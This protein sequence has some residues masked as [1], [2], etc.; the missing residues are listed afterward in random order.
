[1]ALKPIEALEHKERDKWKQA[2]IELRKKRAVLSERESVARSQLKNAIKN[3]DGTEALAEK[4]LGETHADL[5]KIEH[6]LA[7]GGRRFICNDATTEKLAELCQA[8]PYGLM[9]SRDELSGWFEMLTKAGREG[10]RQFFLEAWTGA[11]GHSYDR[12][13]RG[14]PYIPH[15]CLSLFGTI[16]PGKLKYFVTSAGQDGG[17]ADGLLQRFQ[18]L[19][20]PDSRGPRKF[21]DESPNKEAQENYQNVFDNLAALKWQ[22]LFS[23]KNGIALDGPEGSPYYYFHFEDEA[24]SRANEWFIELEAQIDLI[25]V[26]A[27]KA[28]MGKYRGLMPRLALNYFLI[29]VSAERITTQ[30]IPLEAVEFAIEW[31]KHLEAHA[32]K[33]WA[34]NINPALMPAKALAKRILEGTVE[35]RTSL[36]QIQQKNWSKLTKVK[37]VK[38][39]VNQLEKWGWLKQEVLETQGAPSTIILLN[40]ELPL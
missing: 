2:E 33:L 22:S 20:F 21:I 32:R 40:P 29:E 3:A 13:G 6:K 17:E 19:L 12:I 5:I 18:I 9:L 35:D 25:N 15:I 16:Q 30:K 24:Q 14:S 37:D 11:S 1:M 8:N 34:P 26:D 39:G 38:L 31:C 23:L 28:L 7:Q 4:V 10:D 36:S 27:F